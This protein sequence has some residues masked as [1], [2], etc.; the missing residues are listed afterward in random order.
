VFDKKIEL[1]NIADSGKLITK[2]LQEFNNEY[3]RKRGRIVKIKDNKLAIN[4]GAADG[5]VEGALI[6]VYEEDQAVKFKDIKIKPRGKKIIEALVTKVVGKGALAEL[7]SPLEA[8]KIKEGYYVEY[9][10]E[11]MQK[12]EESASQEVKIKEDVKAIEKE[13]TPVKEEIKS[14]EKKPEVKK[15]GGDF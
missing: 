1:A 15:Q 11:P 8:K 5:L 10:A 13:E 14:E 3:P 6:T 9:N 2:A 4:L 12:Q 7:D